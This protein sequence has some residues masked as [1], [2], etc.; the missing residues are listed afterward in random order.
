MEPEEVGMWKRFLIR[1]KQPKVQVNWLLQ[2][3]VG[4]V[5]IQI[6]EINGATSMNA[7]ILG[8]VVMYAVDFIVQKFYGKDYAKDDK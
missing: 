7:I 8:L 4:S 1:I 5:A 2:I 6:A 3:M